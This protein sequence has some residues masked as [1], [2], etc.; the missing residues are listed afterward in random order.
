MMVFKL[1]VT[2]IPEIAHEKTEVELRERIGSFSKECLKHIEPQEKTVLPTEEGTSCVCVCVC[3]LLHQCSL[4]MH[5][6]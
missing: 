1:L 4:L 5:L 3:V 2:G 6:L